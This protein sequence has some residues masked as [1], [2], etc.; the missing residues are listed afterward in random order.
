[1]SCP[2]FVRTRR[3][4]SAVRLLGEGHDEDLV[5]GDAANDGVDDEV[6]DDIGL[7]GPRRSL[8]QRVLVGGHLDD[9]RRLE[10]LRKLRGRAHGACPALSG[11]SFAEALEIEVESPASD[12]ARVLVGE[13]AVV[14]GVRDRAEARARLVRRKRAQAVEYGFTRQEVVVDP[15]AHVIDDG[16]EV[17]EGRLPRDGG[18]RELFVASAAVT[19]VGGRVDSD[20]TRT[21]GP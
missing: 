3:F 8:D 7:A 19:R 9:R 21:A 10:I 2:S 15:G 5:D 1:M 13:H 17:A 16:I 4:N 6:L 18:E 11:R 20:G 12:L 14:V